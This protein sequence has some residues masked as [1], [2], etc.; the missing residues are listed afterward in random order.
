MKPKGWR[1]EKARHSLAAR[2]I[3]TGTKKRTTPKKAKPS[4]PT[5]E[6]RG[7]KVVMIVDGKVVAEQKVK[8]YGEEAITISGWKA[9]VKGKGYG[10]ELLRHVLKTH[11]KAWL[12]NTDGFTTK[13][14]ENFRKVANEEGYVITEWSYSGMGRAVRQDAIDYFIEEEEKGKRLM[15]RFDPNMHSRN[16]DKMCTECHIN[17]R[18]HGSICVICYNKKHK[19]D[20]P[21]L[22]IEE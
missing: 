8:E 2:G 15:W 7:D 21:P 22:I 19:S 13:G 17:K 4:K 20:K 18:T 10:K 12:I 16:R 5:Y 6:K 9:K 11:P 1:R 3:K 14:F